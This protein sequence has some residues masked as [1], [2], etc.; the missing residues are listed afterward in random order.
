M[1][2]CVRCG[3]M[4]IRTSAAGALDRAVALLLWKRSVVC[5]RCGWRGR[6]PRGGR[7]AASV[8]ESG[9]AART[10]GSVDL[11]DLDR[12][13]EAASERPARTREG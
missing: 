4:R 10:S 5:G 8:A 11:S 9:G 12:A 3:S 13:F 2:M 1:P 7:S 6:V